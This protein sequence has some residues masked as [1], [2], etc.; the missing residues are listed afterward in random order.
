[1]D[2]KTL[3]RHIQKETA[4]VWNTLCKMY[5]P[6]AKHNPPKIELNPYMW[7]TA[8]LCFQEENRVQLAYKF[9]KANPQYRNHMLKVILPHELIHQADF[10]LFGESEKICGHGVNWQNIMIQY[11]LNPD[12][13]HTMEISK[14][15]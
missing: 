12:P 5:T 4:M 6:L 3:L 14:N 11:G 7:R 8:G 1:M 2:K 10:N 15:A 9:F 13:Y